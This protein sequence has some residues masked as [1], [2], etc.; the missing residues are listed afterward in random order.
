MDMREDV[1]ASES[2]GRIALEKIQPTSENFRL[3]S[4]GWIENG[5]KPE[6]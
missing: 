2:Y 3:Y 6:T 5:G 4:A 1:F